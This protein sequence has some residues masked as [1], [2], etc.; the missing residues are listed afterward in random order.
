MKEK[1]ISDLTDICVEEAS[2][3]YDNISSLRLPMRPSDLEEAGA[4]LFAQVEDNINA[5]YPGGVD[6]LDSFDDDLGDVKSYAEWK[7][8][9]A[10]SESR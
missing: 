6:A 4:A 9:T 1:A 2:D 10:F 8:E 3:F 7:V 5:A